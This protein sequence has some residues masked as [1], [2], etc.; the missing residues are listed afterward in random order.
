MFA[1]YNDDAFANF[2]NYESD[3][4]PASSGG[5]IGHVSD[6]GGLGGGGVAGA[7]E[8]AGAAAFGNEGG[9]GGGGEGTGN[10]GMDVAM[11]TGTDVGDTAAA[12]AVAPP[13]VYSPYV[14]PNPAVAESGVPLHH[15]HHGA[16]DRTTAPLYAPS[17]AAPPSRTYA[18]AHGHAHAHAHN[19]PMRQERRRTR[20]SARRN[21]GIFSGAYAYCARVWARK[22]DLVKL[23]V[24][25]AI[26]VFALATH[27]F[28]LHYVNVIGSTWDGENAVYA[29]VALRLAY[30]AV[31]LLAMWLL[32]VHAASTVPRAP[33]AL[34]AP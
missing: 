27:A 18:N 25:S 3:E 5:Y 26:I 7:G 21:T 17:P 12:A 29:E 34:V 9:G 30:P 4:I 8:D 14:P 10:E 13:P 19:L 11:R 24:L 20:K 33:A 32:K 1:A 15:P 23:L 22:Y 28:V 16:Y 31:A 6:E 2:T